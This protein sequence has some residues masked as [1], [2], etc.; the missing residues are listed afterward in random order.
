MIKVLRS[1]F[2][3]SIQDLGRQGVM[4]YGV[5]QSGAMDRYAARLANMLLGNEETAAVMEI[6]MT[7]PVLE[8]ETDTYIC[9]SGAEMSPKLNDS[10]IA[11][12]KPIKVLAGDVLS[13][14]KLQ[15]GF[16]SYLAVLGGLLTETV[17]H[18]RSMYQGITKQVTLFK[19]DVLP[20]ASSKPLNTMH[21]ANIRPNSTYLT[22]NRLAVFKGP[23]FG[24][25]SREQQEHLLSFQFSISK[26]HNRMG[27]HLK[28]RLEHNLGSII[29][30]PVLPGTVQLTPSG[31]LIVLM[32]DCQTTGGYPR[33]LQ[34][35][36]MA[37]H[38]LAQKFTGQTVRFKLL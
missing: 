21:H 24:M 9:L 11:V 17:L 30:S 37:M 7:G 14:G 2:Y 1:G 12:N 8:F 27:Y 16:R 34:L 13:F 28:E 18:S 23:E 22:E 25:L 19:N 35:S 36:E 33:I 5:P 15:T 20:I 29:T 6:T 4:H 3:S 26:T 32:R 10:I 31:T 38:T